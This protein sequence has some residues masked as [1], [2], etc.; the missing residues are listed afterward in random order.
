MAKVTTAKGPNLPWYVILDLRYVLV[1]FEKIGRGYVICIR[2][3][4]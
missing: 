2:F 3:Q 4:G 1:P